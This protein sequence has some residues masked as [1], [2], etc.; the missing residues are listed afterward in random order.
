MN[1]S[2]VANLYGS[3]AQ[4][5]TPSSSTGTEEQGT[6]STSGRKGNVQDIVDLS[7][8]AQAAQSFSVGSGYDSTGK[9]MDQILQDMRKMM[10]VRIQETG[11]DTTSAI[12]AKDAGSFFGDITDRRAL[13][14]IYSDESNLFTKA[15][16]DMAYHTVWEMRKEA[17]HGPNMSRLETSKAL[18]DFAEQASP[19]E[20]ATMGWVKDRAYSQYLYEQAREKQNIPFDS[21]SRYDTI[22]T[23]DSTI[24]SLI[25]RLVD[26]EWANYSRPINQLVALEDSDAYKDVQNGFENLLSS[27]HVFSFKDQPQE[28]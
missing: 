14:A 21:T 8:K 11:L 13:Y 23:G 16:R 2:S 1:I 3:P 9:S 22:N 6:S 20:K 5:K 7:P 12:N 19:E 15:E 17:A 25:R 26:E 27:N 24:D 4:S 18:I 10:D 28:V